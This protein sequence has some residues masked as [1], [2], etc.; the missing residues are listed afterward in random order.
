MA[1]N[2]VTAFAVTRAASVRAAEEQALTLCSAEPVRG[3]VPCVLY[4][5]GNQVVFPQLRTRP[6]P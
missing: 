3:A 6:E 5:I 1:I 4:A 2:T